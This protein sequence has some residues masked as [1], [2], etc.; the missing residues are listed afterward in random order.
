MSPKKKRE[1]GIHDI[2]PGIRARRIARVAPRQGRSLL[3][4]AFV[5]SVFVNLLMLT[6]PLYMLQVYD[7][8]LHS[9][10]IETLAA[11]SILVT[12]LY[13]L[14]ALLD[15]ARGRVMARMGA[16]F[17]GPAH[18]GVFDATLRRRANPQEQAMSSAALRDLDAVQSLFA[19]PVL[20]ALMDMPW[21]PV[22]IARSSCS[23]RCWAG[24]P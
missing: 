12:G 4:W 15:Y 16:K 9:R 2:T 5:F 21:T 7:R 3:M 10:S 19:S 6:G 22:F 18:A 23:T 13:A 11:L 20:L 14:M 8:V 1:A 24:F 17:A